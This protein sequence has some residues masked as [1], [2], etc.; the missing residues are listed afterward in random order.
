MTNVYSAQASAFLFNN[1]DSNTEYNNMTVTVSNS[2]FSY[3]TS[4]TKG[5][6]YL[7]SGL[8]ITLQIKNSTFDSNYGYNGPADIYLTDITS[9]SISNST[10]NNF[11]VYSSS[12]GQSMHMVVSSSSSV[13]PSLTNVEMY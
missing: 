2:K 7:S 5:A 12:Y 13:T 11:T 6:F 3:L 10:F 1:I 4:F 9:L 8:G